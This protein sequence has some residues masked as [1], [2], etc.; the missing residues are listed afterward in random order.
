[1]GKKGF[2]IKRIGD[3]SDDTTSFSAVETGPGTFDVVIVSEGISFYLHDIKDM[4]G[5]I[6]SLKEEKKVLLSS[7]RMVMEACYTKEE[8]KARF[9][10]EEVLERYDLII[11]RCTSLKS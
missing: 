9:G 1:M 10:K 7:D 5:L 3:L 4:E 2:D 11:E 8:A 6:K